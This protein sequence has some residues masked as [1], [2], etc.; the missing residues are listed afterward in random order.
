MAI[1]LDFWPVAFEWKWGKLLPNLA[2]KNFPCNSFLSLNSTICCWLDVESQSNFGIHVL[3]VAEPRSLNKW[4][5]FILLR[6][7]IFFFGLT[8]VETNVTLINIYTHN[9]IYYC[10]CSPSVKFSVRVHTICWNTVELKLCSIN[11]KLGQVFFVL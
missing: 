7:W 4:E 3:R 6:H 9:V 11:F 1:W 10:N 5:V 2:H 8:S